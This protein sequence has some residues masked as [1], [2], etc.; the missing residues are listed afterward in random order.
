[1]IS[2]ASSLKIP[3]TSISPSDATRG[4]DKRNWK[5]AGVEPGTMSA[6]EITISIAQYIRFNSS[7]VSLRWNFNLSVLR[8]RRGKE[9]G[10]GKVAALKIPRILCQNLSLHDSCKW[11]LS[12]YL[13]YYFTSVEEENNSW[14]ITWFCNPSYP[15]SSIQE[16][17]ANSKTY[18]IMAHIS[19]TNRSY[20]FSIKDSL[21]LQVSWL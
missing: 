15:I 19:N 18:S 17:S 14:G 20:T 16:S 10:G 7:Y 11:M 6:L 4:K 5:S 2:V 1:M 13:F 21:L 9:V 12:R 3:F 8:G